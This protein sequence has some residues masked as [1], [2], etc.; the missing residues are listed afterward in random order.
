MALCLSIACFLLA[1][2]AFLVGFITEFRQ[3]RASGPVAIV[4]A[5][6]WA[7]ESAIFVLLGL[8]FL[9][10]RISWWGF[11]LVFFGSAFGFGWGIT[12]ANG[13]R[14]GGGATT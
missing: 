12:R 9:P 1:V 14:P 10:Y 8:I 7:V 3:S 5:L 2:V 6:P 4:P 11:P 13:R